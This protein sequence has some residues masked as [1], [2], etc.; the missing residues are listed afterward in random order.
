MVNTYILVNPHIEGDFKSKIKAQNSDEAAKLFYKNLS[1]HFNN[2]VPKFHFSI[3]KGSSGEGKY[4]HFKVSEKR[5]DNEVSFSIKPMKIKGEDENNSNFKAR[6]DKFK[7][8]WA[9]GGGDKHKKS[10]HR[11]SKDSDS[12]DSDSS[13]S[14]DMIR[15][16]KYVSNQPIYYWWYDP[17]VYRLDSVFIP[18]FY[19]YITPRIEYVLYAY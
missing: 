4:Y 7:T 14:D 3:Q 17:F 16:K 10:K 12:S 9:Q 19:S 5:S 15:D 6:L 8:K 2:H 18:T 13:S 1:E 11:K